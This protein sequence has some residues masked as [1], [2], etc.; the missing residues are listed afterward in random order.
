LLST[1]I[2]AIDRFFIEDLTRF[3]KK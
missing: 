1:Q 2:N 3:I